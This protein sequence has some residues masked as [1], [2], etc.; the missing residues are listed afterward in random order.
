MILT[1]K[2]LL[3]TIIFAFV[4]LSLIPFAKALPVAKTPEE[5]GLSS[6]KLEAIT[7][8]LELL[9]NTRQIAGGVLTVIRNG[10]V[11]Y[12]KT[13][14]F[15]NL[16]TEELIQV[17]DIFRIASMTKI[18]T[19]FAAYLLKQ[20][21]LIDFNDPVSKY[22]ESY[23]S[24]KVLI[25]G[26]SGEASDFTTVTAKN[27]I[28]IQHLLNHTSGLK[29]G[30]SN[31]ISGNSATIGEA[32]EKLVN[33]PLQFEPGSA[34]LYSNLNS[35]LLGYLIE[36]VSKQTLAEFFEARIFQPLEMKDTSFFVREEKLDRLTTVYTP[37]NNNLKP[38]VNNADVFKQTYFSGGG[39][40]YSTINDYSR[41]LQM[42]LSQG[43]LIS[44][45]GQTVIQ[46][47]DAKTVE[48]FLSIKPEDLEI[49]PFFQQLLGG[50]SYR[51]TNGM[52]VKSVPSETVASIGAFKWFGAYSTYYFVDPKKELIGILM[53]QIPF[54][55]FL[56]QTNLINKFESLIYNSLCNNCQDV[57]P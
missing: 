13:V 8:E 20:D 49:N 39:G 27:Q 4:Y 24:L 1:Q 31:S 38:L 37:K 18:I 6:S 43:Q 56:L 5:I 10:K 55:P 57:E 15:R 7:E 50:A 46:V 34:F 28:T 44:K 12:R 17:N 30:I 51:F 22:I 9:V 16:E 3:K 45:D 33:I 11:G 21:N 52:A 53:T 54:A 42:L 48:E 25:P 40:L 41:F 36:V 23:G 2:P 35:D 14:G 32:M 29:A 19:G 26:K 47:A